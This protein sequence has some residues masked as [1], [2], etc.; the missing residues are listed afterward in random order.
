[1]KFGKTYDERILA[2]QEELKRLQKGI[3]HFAW[4]PEQMKN[5]RWIWLEHY[6]AI[7]VMQPCGF[8]MVTPVYTGGAYDQPLV[9]LYEDRED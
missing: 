8:G 6:I 9:Y 4:V 7:H 5:G 1:M 2:R 3:R